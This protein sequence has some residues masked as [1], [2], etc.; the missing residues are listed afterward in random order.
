MKAM[1]THRDEDL[2]AATFPGTA[3][4]FLYSGK[5]RGLRHRAERPIIYKESCAGFGMQCLRIESHRTFVY[6][7]ML[8]GGYAVEEATSRKTPIQGDEDWSP[9]N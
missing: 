6:P 5:H 7:W 3:S 2:Q 8:D 4:R 1:K 9:K